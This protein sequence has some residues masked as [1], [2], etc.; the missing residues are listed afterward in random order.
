MSETAID[1]HAIF[2]RNFPLPPHITTLHRLFRGNVKMTDDASAERIGKV[3]YYDTHISELIE[4]MKSLFPSWK[5]IS[6]EPS[7]K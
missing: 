6:A 7:R 2:K 1:R 3:R 4:D 5:N